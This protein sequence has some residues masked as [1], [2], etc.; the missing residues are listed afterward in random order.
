MLPPEVL[1]ETPVS[2]VIMR[3]S[4]DFSFFLFK[5]PSKSRENYPLQG[6]NLREVIPGP[7]L[8]VGRPPRCAFCPCACLQ[9][10]EGLLLPAQATP[11]RPRFETS[12]LLFSFSV[13][14]TGSI[15]EHLSWVSAFP[16][17]ARA[18][19]GMES[20][21]LETCGGARGLDCLEPKF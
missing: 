21:C 9:G 3:L 5:L 1:T 2:L 18:I 8:W 17:G 6:Q 7:L 11:E 16:S 19:C 10:W 13:V 20:I 12:C 14:C 4:V 15:C